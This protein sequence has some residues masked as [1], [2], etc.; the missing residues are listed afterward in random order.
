MN[1]E[2][3]K[4]GKRLKLNLFKRKKGYIQIYRTID[5]NKVDLNNEED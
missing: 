1:K 3:Q 5:L 4:Y 2:I